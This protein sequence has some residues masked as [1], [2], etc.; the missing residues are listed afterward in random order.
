M[1]DIISDI[2]DRYRTDI[3]VI[4]YVVE[5][6]ICEKVVRATCEG[7]D[8][9]STASAYLCVQLPAALRGELAALARRMLAV[10]SPSKP[11]IVETVK[12]PGATT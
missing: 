3:M 11:R 6:F 9:R 8:L 7:V 5:S 10:A 12:R 4:D 1:F 2:V